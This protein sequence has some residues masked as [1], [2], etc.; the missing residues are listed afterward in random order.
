MTEKIVDVAIIG[1]GSAGMAAYKS[2]LKFTDNIALIEG[3]QYGTTCARVGCMPSKLLISAAEAAHTVEMSTRFGITIDGKV[4]VDG[5]KVMQRV[6]SERDRFVGFVVE[7]VDSIKPEHKIRGFA[8]FIDNNTLIVNEDIVIKAKAIIIATGSSPAILPFLENLGDRLTVND[9]IFDWDKLPESVA[10]FG[11]GVIGLELGQALHRLGVRIKIF[12]RRGTISPLNDPE[13]KEYATRAFSEEL[14]LDTHFQ[15]IDI[16]KEND[17]I[18]IRYIGKDN[19]E[20]EEKYEFALSATGRKPNLA[21]LGLENT[22]VELDNNGIPHY[23]KNTMQCGNTSIFIAGDVGNYIPLLHEASDEGTIAGR[24]AARFPEISRVK[25]RAPIEIV[26]TDPQIGI[27]GLNFQ[28]LEP[29]SFAT[30]KVSFENQGR[31]RILLKNKGLLHLYAEYSTGRFLGAE[32]FGPHAEHLAH[33]LAWSYQQ[34][35]TIEQMLE[36]PFYH[37]VIE[38]G[39]RTALRDASHQLKVSRAL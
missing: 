7:T 33:L 18:I 17:G 39:L 13:V 30:G 20:K 5:T 38:E 15:F 28:S 32:I 3:G 31:S 26:F 27:V 34:E 23:D 11:P 9:H 16:K 8:K 19:I 10:V 24:N 12:G 2:S 25:R 1:T 35:M 37:P 4:S 29:G 36:M 22:T 21:N 14:D 6:K